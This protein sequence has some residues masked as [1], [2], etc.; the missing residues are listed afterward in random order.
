MKKHFSVN[1]R[2]RY[3]FRICKELGIDDPIAWMNIVPSS[4]VDQWIAF[5]CCS[6][7]GEVESEK[8]P[9]EQLKKLEGFMNG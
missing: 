6:D 3:V 4:L 5:F 8:S 1:H 9:E 7:D 2:L